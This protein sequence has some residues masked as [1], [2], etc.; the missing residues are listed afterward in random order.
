[1]GVS[2][3]YA[4]GSLESSAV[5]TFRAESVDDVVTAVEL[6]LDHEIVVLSSA[7]GGTVEWGT[8]TFIVEICGRL[9]KMLVY[10]I[11][12]PPPMIER[13]A[14]FFGPNAR[15]SRTYWRFDDILSAKA[16]D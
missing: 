9:A 16:F 1:M 5:G 7:P 12:G 2:L 4:D 11:P 13:D 3:R 14:I 8:H 10:D 15:Y 6:A